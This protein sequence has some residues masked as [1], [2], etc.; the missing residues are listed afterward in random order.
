MSPLPYAVTENWHPDRLLVRGRLARNASDR[1]VAIIGC[2]ALGS[3]LAELLVRMG[4][5]S[6]LLVD[7]QV[8]ESGNVVR[9]ALTNNDSGKPK[10]IALA[11]MLRAVSPLVRIDSYD[12]DLPTDRD[13]L[14]ELLDDCDVVVECTAADDVPLLLST[15]WWS[16]PRLFM[17]LSCGFKARRTFIYRSRGHGFPAADFHAKLAPWL[18][19]EQIERSGAG[20]LLEGAG[21]YSPISPARL[22]D[23]TL[24]AVAAVKVFE[25]SLASVAA[26]DNQLLVL[27]P[28]GEF[29]GLTEAE[30]P[31]A[32]ANAQGV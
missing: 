6:M 15:A 21:C 10:A 8:L 23:L 26:I 31:Q 7:G 11:A 30:L 22:D 9:H 19:S 28:R 13:A 24:A 1:R 4:V 20:E 14:I 5:R 12:D 25:S 16:V 32:G 2:G 29:G 3:A 27:E 18:A 17:S